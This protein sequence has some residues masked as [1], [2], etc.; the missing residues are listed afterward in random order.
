MILDSH[1]YL[2]SSIVGTR[3][4]DGTEEVVTINLPDHLS[5]DEDPEEN[6]N[7]GSTIHRTIPT[8]NPSRIP[9]TEQKTKELE[10]LLLSMDILKCPTCQT[11]YDNYFSLQA[12]M[13]NVHKTRAACV[14]CCNEK[15][16]GLLDILDHM[17][18]HLDPH[19]FKCIDCEHCA[20]SYG[21]LRKHQIKEKH[22]RKSY[23]CPQCDKSF[24]TRIRL[25]RHVNFH[26]PKDK[27][28]EKCDHCTKAFADKPS[29]RRHIERMHDVT[30]RC[31]CQVST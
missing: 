5:T 2:H 30:E 7:E 12:H 25:E 19:T 20:D 6:S 24:P 9:R 8:N 17:E 28:P 1:Q 21:N 27:R 16:M 26:L 10:S 31:V 23:P 18:F 11:H 14:Q 22:N 13:R 15:R 4:M 3:Q 29:L